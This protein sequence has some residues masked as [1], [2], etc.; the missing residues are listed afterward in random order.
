MDFTKIFQGGDM[1]SPKGAQIAADYVLENPEFIFEIVKLITCGDKMIQMRAADCLEKISAQNHEILSPIHGEILQIMKI[2]KQKEVRWHL[3][4]IVPR[5][6]S[7]EKEIDEIAPI[8]FDYINDT[9]KIVA[10]FALDA[11]VNFAKKNEKLKDQILP[12]LKDKA[13]NGNGAIKARAKILL[14]SF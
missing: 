12:I 9:S 3:A 11:L 8:L 14:K 4:Q 13:Q 5:I 7:D 10:T 6:V 1:R 2:S